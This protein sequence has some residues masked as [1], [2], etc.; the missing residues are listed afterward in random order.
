MNTQAFFLFPVSFFQLCWGESH[1]QSL[2]MELARSGQWPEF[3][4]PVKMALR[5][6]LCLH[7][8]SDILAE[9]SAYSWHFP[10]ANI[11]LSSA[12]QVSFVNMAAGWA[13]SGGITETDRCWRCTSGV[14]A[15]RVCANLGWWQPCRTGFVYWWK[16]LLTTLLFMAT[17]SGS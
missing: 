14:S 16:S 2:G 17:I 8:S 5:P 3:Q 12:F 15:S 4:E 11:V 1:S 13:R 10:L 7:I 9:G 6:R